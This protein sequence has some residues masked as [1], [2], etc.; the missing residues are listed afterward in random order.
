VNGHVGFVA[1]QDRAGNLMVLGGN[2]GDAVSIK[3]FA[4]GR[5]LGFRWPADEPLPEAAAL[6]VLTSSGALSRNEA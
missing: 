4:R 2:Q 3:P 1:G 6:P 5:V